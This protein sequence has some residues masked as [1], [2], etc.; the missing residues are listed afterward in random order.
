MK[1]RI[2]LTTVTNFTIRLLVSGQTT[3]DQAIQN[4][5]S[6][7]SNNLQKINLTQEEKTR[8][9]SINDPIE[10]L[11]QAEALENK[12]QE[13]RNQAKLIL[14]EATNLDKQV[15][16][17]KIVASEISGKLCREKFALC[18]E[19]S[20]SIMNANHANDANLKQAKVLINEASKEVQMAKEMREEAYAWENNNARLGA[21]SNVEEKEISALNKMDEALTILKKMNRVS[22]HKAD[23]RILVEIGTLAQQSN[24]HLKP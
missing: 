18:I 15:T 16:T 17:V 22:P 14:Q 24:T 20:D 2:L 9:I 23:K 11:K 13:L 21:L 8:F 12:A 5:D 6:F 3:A 1:T 19:S 4:Y 7:F 10:I